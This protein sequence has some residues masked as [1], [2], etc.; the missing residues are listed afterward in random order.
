MT[1]DTETLRHAYAE[2]VAECNDLQDVIADARARGN[3]DEED[4]IEEAEAAL[5]VAQEKADKA[6]EAFAQAS[7]NWVTDAPR[8]FDAVMVAGTAS[9]T[10]GLVVPTVTFGFRGSTDDEPVTV[11]LINDEVQ[12]RKFQRDL[13]KAITEAVRGVARVRKAKK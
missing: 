12:L 2:A 1:T 13:D 6:Y 5:L 7:A 4:T 8:R 3:P 10:S 11:T 9:T